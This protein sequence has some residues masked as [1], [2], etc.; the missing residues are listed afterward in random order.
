M[1]ICLRIRERMCIEL[2]GNC[3]E[4][5]TIFTVAPTS[6]IGRLFNATHD[7]L[8]IFLIDDYAAFGAS[9]FGA[10][11]GTEIVHIDLAIAEFLHGLQAVP[12]ASLVSK[13]LDDG[14]NGSN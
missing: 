5:S 10:Q 7:V 13:R 12:M 3:T 2:A 11:F 6:L 14:G 9:G 8:H 1:G 4:V